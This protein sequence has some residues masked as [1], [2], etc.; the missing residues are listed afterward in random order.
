VVIRRPPAARLRGRQGG[1]FQVSNLLFL[2]TERRFIMIARRGISP[3]NE[4]ASLFANRFRTL[5]ATP[6]GR[7]GSA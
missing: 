3:Y 7:T 5:S 4:F 1:Q 6:N 2:Y